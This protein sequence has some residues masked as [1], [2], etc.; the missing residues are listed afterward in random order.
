MSDHLTMQDLKDFT[1]SVGQTE[2]AAIT[3][4][5][6]EYK[7][8]N[9]LITYKTLRARGGTDREFSQDMILLCAIVLMRGTN[10]S[11]IQEK[12]SDEG[13]AILMP[14]V[15]RYRIMDHKKDEVLGNE[16]IILGR[17]TATFPPICMNLLISQKVV[18]AVDPGS[19]PPAL[20]FSGGAALIST[21]REG[22]YQ[23]WLDWSLRFDRLI[24]K[25]AKTTLTLTER[26]NEVADYG[27]IIRNSQMFT[28]SERDN[29]LIR[30]QSPGFQID[31]NNYPNEPGASVAS[32]ENG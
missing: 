25:K 19:C 31:F 15:R 13:N 22:L 16:D 6:F 29:M 20:C 4:T 12:T 8:F 9:P 24:N 14:L 23:A 5:K 17:I 30:I 10:L 2:I 18:P 11:K 21:E 7:G 27:E 28:N 26:R 1:M 32:G 3:T